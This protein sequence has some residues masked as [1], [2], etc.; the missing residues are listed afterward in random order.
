MALL[1]ET[2][3]LLIK[4]DADGAVQAF[5]KA[6][7]AAERDLGRAQTEA[8]KT[9]AKLTKMG[10]ASL[11]AGGVA[12]AALYSTIKPA[13]DLA[14]AINVTGLTFGESAAEMEAWAAGAAE[15]FG[16]SK[17]QALEGAS[18][19]GGLLQN[20][21]FLEAESADLSRQLVVLASD[22]GSAFNM[23]PAEALAALRSGLAGESE[24]LKRF[25][26]FLSEAAVNAKAFELGISD[27]TG[28]LSEN[29]K[30]QARLAIIME[31]TAKIQGD[32]ANTAD[33]AANSQRVL[34]AQMEDL[35]ASI[36]QAVLPIFQEV[37]GALTAMA[38]AFSSLPPGMQTV[39][40]KAAVLTTGLLLLGGAA[41][42]VAGRVK[43][44]KASLSSV[45]G[46]K[47]TAAAAGIGVLAA[48]INAFA[49]DAEEG[50]RR[51]RAMADAIGEMGTE[52]GVVARI[53]EIA[54]ESE[55]L[56][57]I[58]A[59]LGSEG[60]DAVAEGLARGFD[61]DGQ[62]MDVLREFGLNGEQAKLVM[63]RLR[64]EFK[65]AQDELSDF[66]AITGE[67]EGS[68]AALAG[69]VDSLYRAT[70]PAAGAVADFG[71]RVT[72]MTEPVRTFEE[73]M[74]DAADAMDRFF[75]SVLS[76][77]RIE[78]NFQ[79]ALDDAAAAIETHGASFDLSTEAGRANLA[80]Q[81]DVVQSLHD[82]AAAMVEQRAPADEIRA[83]LQ[84]MVDDYGATLLAADANEFQV[85]L[86]T[87]A[88]LGIPED[89]YTELEN[90]GYDESIAELQMIMS[91]LDQIK[92]QHN[93][94]VFVSPSFASAPSGGGTVSDD[95]FEL[96][97]LEPRSAGKPRLGRSGGRGGGG[98]DIVIEH[99]TNL[100]G[101]PILRSIERV[102]RAEG[103]ARIQIRAGN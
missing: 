22:M 38:G 34:A 63:V 35:K 87:A 70:G 28:A 69:S 92:G 67:S 88:L 21:G 66:S 103:G 84:G 6:G 56:R 61:N 57:N 77:E 46:V 97:P 83:R 10:A 81:E 43:D 40:A 1:K 98:G 20:V 59:D 75:G 32:F 100:D 55:G 94:Q 41:L 37:V 72:I 79:Q 19:I 16:Q 52:K 11:A 93:A 64:D 27:G 95:E 31:Q 60:I 29:E 90:T 71:D 49:Q 17:R 62:F 50:E 76:G 24:P 78:A 86:L 74:Q 96:A 85:G 65:G 7:D 44:L 8:E 51:A 58:F 54:E 73:Q 13:S 4:G 5:R 26:V 18:A 9:S 89:V 101:K 91:Y 45:N 99:T 68:V 53:H 12:A 47:F 25:N 82:T 33:G 42:S 14:E 39:I 2:L 36:G 80:V 3:S 30:A 15:A 48:T 102:S 23:D